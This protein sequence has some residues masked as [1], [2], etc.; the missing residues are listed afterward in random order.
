MIQWWTTGSIRTKQ[1]RSA[2]HDGVAKSRAWR[3][4][5]SVMV[6][7]EYQD[8]APCV[9]VTPDDCRKD[10]MKRLGNMAAWHENLLPA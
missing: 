3:R 5:D 9:A 7:K 10:V 1:S 6:S 8:H 2:R 4:D